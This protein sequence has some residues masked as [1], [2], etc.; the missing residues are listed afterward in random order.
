[1]IQLQSPKRS[2]TR[3][4][5]AEKERAYLGRAGRGTISPELQRRRGGEGGREMRTQEPWDGSSED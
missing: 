3:F 1:M 5:E 2:T 4:K